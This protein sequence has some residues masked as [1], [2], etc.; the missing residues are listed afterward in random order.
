M[1]DVV[2]SAGLVAAGFVGVMARC[3]A[4]MNKDGLESY[5]RETD[6]E[7]TMTARTADGTSSGWHGQANRDWGKVEAHVVAATAVDIAQRGANPKAVEPGRHVAILTPLAVVQLVHLMTSAFDAIQTDSGGTPFSMHP[8]GS[9]RGLRVFDRRLSMSSDPADADGGYRP[10]FAGGMP[11]PKMTWVENGVLTNLAYSPWYAMET[12]QRYAGD[13]WSFRM[14]GGSAS[15][16]S[17]IAACQEGILVNR[18]SNLE[19]SDASK[20]TVTG[21][22]RDGCFLV[23]QGKIV[24]PVKNFRFRDSPWFFLN[25]I[26]SLGVPVRAAFG[27]TPPA[28]DESFGDSTA[29]PRR[30]IIVPPMMVQDF[31]F[32]SLAEAV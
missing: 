28:A 31:N 3:A 4:V 2:R 13:P 24:Q 12:G 22:T 9:K 16:E 21:V 30:P 6:C 23:R 27:Y 18:V 7:C 8:T 14:S 11:E 20:G 29:W 1:I 25:N 15:I 10:D 26:L 5:Y 32:T 19:L 17:M